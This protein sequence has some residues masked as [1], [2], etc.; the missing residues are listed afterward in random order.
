M[1]QFRLVVFA[2]GVTILCMKV[3]TPILLAI[4]TLYSW[5]MAE[6][7]LWQA[8][9][10]AAHARAVVFCGVWSYVFGSALVVSL[11]AWVVCLVSLWRKKS[12][13]WL[14]T[15]YLSLWALLMGGGLLW[16]KYLLPDKM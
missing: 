4:G 3:L 9:Y 7:Y 1:S 13:G 2:V 6:Y 10:H 14:C 12:L 5:Y 11:V 16:I 15:V 8:A